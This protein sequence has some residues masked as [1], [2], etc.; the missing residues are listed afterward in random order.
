MVGTWFEPG[1][2][3]DESAPRGNSAIKKLVTNR[4]LPLNTLYSCTKTL[5]KFTVNSCLRL[6]R[7]YVTFELL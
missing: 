6:G 1:R 4:Q 2:T 7:L 3:A 5:N